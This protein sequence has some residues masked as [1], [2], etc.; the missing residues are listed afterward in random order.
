MRTLIATALCLLLSISILASPK[1]KLKKGQRQ[2]DAARVAEIQ[3]ALVANGYESGK[4]W[5]ETKEILRDIADKRE[6]QTDYAPD[7]R[8]LG[9]VLHL[10]N[11]NF[12]SYVC[13]APPNKLDQLQR[14]EK[15]KR[16]Q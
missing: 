12:D 4:T 10:G 6:W 14:A 5:D 13:D 3:A 16:E 8:V 11:V 7:A 9:C 15:D 1:T 2:P